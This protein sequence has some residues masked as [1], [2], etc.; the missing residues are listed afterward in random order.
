[1]VSQCGVGRRGGDGGNQLLGSWGTQQYPGPTLGLR[2]MRQ[3][4]PGGE[5][6]D[7]ISLTPKALP[8]QG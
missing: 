6:K 3:A 4:W 8:G 2:A 5:G 7:G 1:M